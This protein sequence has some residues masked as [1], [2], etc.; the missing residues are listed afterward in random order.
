MEKDLK[1]KGN[2]TKDEPREADSKECKDLLE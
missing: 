1:T 2:R